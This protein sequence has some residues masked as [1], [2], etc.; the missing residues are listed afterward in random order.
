MLVP[1]GAHEARNWSEEEVRL[2][3]NKRKGFIKMA[4]RFGV[5]LVPTFSFNEQNIFNQ[6]IAEK[7]NI[8]ISFTCLRKNVYAVKFH[9]T[10]FLGFIF[11]QIQR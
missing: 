10:S 9:S 11:I 4:L 5:D 6:I 1:G 8:S 7:G 3:L 2:Y